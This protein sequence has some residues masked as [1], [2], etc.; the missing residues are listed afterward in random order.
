MS[1]LRTTAMTFLTGVRRHPG[2]ALAICVPLVAAG[3]LAGTSAASAGPEATL[4]V[5][6][7]ELNAKPAPLVMNFDGSVPGTRVIANKHD[8]P[9]PEPAN[10]SDCDYDY[11]QPNQC[12]PWQIP[13]S[14]PQAKCAWLTANGFGP[15]KLVGVNRQ[16]L[17][18]NAEGYVCAGA[19]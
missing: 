19:S 12:V 15:L 11:G 3:I 5:T 17:P 6:R 18:E 16:H 10:I 4:A 1:K 8:R 7:A 14:A 13:A 9:I 2:R